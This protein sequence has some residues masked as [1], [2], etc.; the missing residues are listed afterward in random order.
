MEMPHE[1]LWI[2]TKYTLFFFTFTVK[3]MHKKLVKNTDI[4]IQK[5]YNYQ[6]HLSFNIKQDTEQWECMKSKYNS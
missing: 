3:L 6:I 1:T 2:K 4:L 5:N